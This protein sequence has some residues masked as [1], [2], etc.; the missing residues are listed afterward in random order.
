MLKAH[1]VGLYPEEGAGFKWALLDPKT[2]D[3]MFGAANHPLPELI[4]CWCKK[5]QVDEAKLE[6]ATD[7]RELRPFDFARLVMD[8]RPRR[9]R[10]WHRGLAR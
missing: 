10:G 2:G 1:R 7:G 6:V 3:V 8:H 4:V 5:H 9:N